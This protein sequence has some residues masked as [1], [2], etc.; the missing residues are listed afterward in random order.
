MELTAFVP[1]SVPYFPSTTIW[2]P[3]DKSGLELKLQES[4]NGESS[5]PK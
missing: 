2:I 4:S 1:V 3:G 5:T